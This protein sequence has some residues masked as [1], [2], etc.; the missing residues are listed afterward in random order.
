MDLDEARS[1]FAQTCMFTGNKHTGF[2]TRGSTSFMA[3]EILILE[4]LLEFAGID[5]MKKLYCF[6]DCFTNDIV[7][8]S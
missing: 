1:A 4:K 5:V 8:S 7:F 2:I 6:T 3:P